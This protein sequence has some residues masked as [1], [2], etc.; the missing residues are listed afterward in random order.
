MP[1]REWTT[2]T[3]PASPAAGGA[4]AAGPTY[5]HVSSKDGFPALDGV[6]TLHELFDRS[7]SK[8]A[9]S[10]CLGWRPIVSDTRQ[11]VSGGW[12]S[13]HMGGLGARQ[14]VARA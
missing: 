5:R 13:V 7:R 14:V 10:P 3:A 2:V 6:A 4:L 8:F 12:V 9:D 11:S 1:R